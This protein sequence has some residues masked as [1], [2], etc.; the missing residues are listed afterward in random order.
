MVLAI[1]K[2]KGF[3]LRM[4][5]SNGYYGCHKCRSPGER[6]P[7]GRTHVQVH[8]YISPED[9]QLRNRDNI[10]A[11]ARSR[12]LGYKGLSL[13]YF[14]MPSMIRGTAIDIMHMTF[15]GICKL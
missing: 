10:P 4:K 3:F 5:L 7:A 6:V 15:L 14:L 2:Q 8:E 11:L 9:M 13:L 1:C 12:R